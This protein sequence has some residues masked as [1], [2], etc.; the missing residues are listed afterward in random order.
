MGEKWLENTLLETGGTG[1]QTVVEVIVLDQYYANVSEFYNY[2][3]V[4]H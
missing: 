4:M 3:V 2:T 1:I